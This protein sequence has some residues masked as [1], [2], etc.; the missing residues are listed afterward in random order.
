MPVCAVSPVLETENEFLRLH[1]ACRQELETLY[2]DTHQLLN[3]LAL[4][5]LF[6]KNK[7]DAVEYHLKTEIGAKQDYERGRRELIDFVLMRSLQEPAKIPAAR[8]GAPVARRSN[9]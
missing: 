5:E 7:H 9:S 4:A 8:R 2:Q 1:K 6:P 3:V